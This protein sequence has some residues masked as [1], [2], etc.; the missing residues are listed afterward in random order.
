MEKIFNCFGMEITGTNPEFV[1]ESFG[2]YDKN[3]YPLPFWEFENDSVD[4]S[5]FDKSHIEPNGN[6]TQEVILPKGILLCRY[7]NPR[8]RF[9]TNVGVP[10][11]MLG[12]PYKKETLEYHE[13][14]VIADGV[15]VQCVVTRG[16]VY[17]MFGSAGGAVQYRHPSIILEE[18][19]N[20]KIREV[21]TWLQKRNPSAL[22]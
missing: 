21:W 19:S 22:M 17:P 12:M 13:Y 8:G 20:G 1:S 10:Y 7:G 16:I 18:V 14:E 11:E 6:Y 3:G 2:K 9:T 4:G 15:K 5:G